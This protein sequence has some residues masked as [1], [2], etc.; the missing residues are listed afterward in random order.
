M[1][2]AVSIPDAV[3]G[4]KV[5]AHAGRPV[6]LTVPKRQ[7]RPIPAPEGPGG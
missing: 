5:E 6:T 4:G 3:L 1:D 2:L 7:Q